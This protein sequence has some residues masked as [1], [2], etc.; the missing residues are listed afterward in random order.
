[1]WYG[2]WGATGSGAREP[3]GTRQFD[4]TTSGRTRSTHTPPRICKVKI[5]NLMNERFRPVGGNTDVPT[6]DSDLSGRGIGFTF[7]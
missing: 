2:R 1:M 5:D 7:G 3:R 6:G 4:T